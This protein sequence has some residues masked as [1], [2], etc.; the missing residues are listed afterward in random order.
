MSTPKPK[1][2]TGGAR[3]AV[4]KAV[5]EQNHEMEG[6]AHR[7]NDLLNGEAGLDIFQHH[8]RLIGE[9][10]MSEPFN[11][12]VKRKVMIQ[13]HRDYGNPYVQRLVDHVT[14]RKTKI[15]S[16]DNNPI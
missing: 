1:S 11:Q 14:R 13:L 16:T 3:H 6:R 10:R 9:D 7:L 2:K 5:P 12:A 15:Q 8:A 4:P